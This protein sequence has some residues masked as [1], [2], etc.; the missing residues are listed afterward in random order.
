M[1]QL[2]ALCATYT[3][4]NSMIFLSDNKLLLLKSFGDKIWVC[5]QT[6]CSPATA[7]TKSRMSWTC[8]TG[9]TWMWSWRARYSVTEKPWAKSTWTGRRTTTN[10]SCPA[11]ENTWSRGPS[12][13]TPR[14][15]SPLQTWSQT[16][17]PTGNS[18]STPWARSL[19]TVSKAALPAKSWAQN[20]SWTSSSQPRVGLSIWTSPHPF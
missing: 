12:D 4:E 6:L 2:C 8:M 5:G 13:L 7:S 18:I 14:V 3:V 17:C 15:S 19:A 10:Y 9:S 1:T 20:I 16:S 11:T